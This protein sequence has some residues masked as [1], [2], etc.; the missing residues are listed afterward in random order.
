MHRADSEE[1]NP[2]W[3][4]GGSSPPSSLAGTNVSVA[5]TGTFHS[6]AP[7]SAESP[8][9]AARLPALCTGGL[10]NPEGWDRCQTSS[11]ARDRQGRTGTTP[12]PP[13]TPQKPISHTKG[14]FMPKPLLFLQL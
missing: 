7:D 5:L 12:E 14:A 2:P 6:L 3:L 1:A 4:G 11:T 9:F 13:W 8:P 10:P